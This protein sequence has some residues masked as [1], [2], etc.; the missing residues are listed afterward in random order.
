MTALILHLLVILIRLHDSMFLNMTEKGNLLMLSE[1]IF[2]NLI[3]SQLFLHTLSGV[4][5]HCVLPSKFVATWL[6][7]TLNN[8]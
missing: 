5:C 1:K 7:M 3:I 2:L 4:I 8:P 6:F